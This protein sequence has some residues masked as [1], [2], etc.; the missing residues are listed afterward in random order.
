MIDADTNA[1]ETDENLIE[2]NKDP[3][4]DPLSISDHEERDSDTTL[5]KSKSKYSV[6]KRRSIR[7]SN[8]R[9]NSNTTNTN[10]NTNKSFKKY[11]GK[12]NTKE[13]HLLE[14]L[15]NIAEQEEFSLTV[16]KKLLVLHI[17]LIH[18]VPPQHKIELTGAHAPTKEEKR[19]FQKHGPLRRG[20]YSPAEDK[21]IRKN[22]NT[23]CDLHNWDPKMIQPFLYWRHNMKY[24]IDNVQERQR[25]VQFLANGL[26]WRTLFSVYSRFKTLYNNKITYTR[27][28]SE[29]DEK[30][31]MYIQNKHLNVRNTKYIELEKLLK[32]TRR[33]II[34]R[35]RFLKKTKNKSKNESSVNI[36]WTLPLIKE[37]IEN[38]LDVTL[39]EDIEELK[40][41][42]LPKSVWQKLEEKLNIHETVLKTFWQHQLHLQLFSTGPIYLND[43]KIKLIEYM[44]GKGISN[45][46]EIIW[47]NVARHFEGTTAAFLCKTFFYLVQDCNLNNVD[48]FADVIEYLYHTK[49]SEIQNA[50][51]DKFLPKIV[52]EQENIYI[53]NEKGD[54]VTTE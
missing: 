14:E 4:K 54:A 32:R 41:A 12:L 51:M 39:S 6:Q 7:L 13:K 17:K 48:N 53:L 35:Y 19:L 27:Y 23:F 34:K 47:P 49:I 20:P 38:L 28:T 24:Y 45:T 30:I 52:Y 36:N 40:Y 18:K 15:E 37:F 44:Y 25:F 11:K 43:I 46:R 21:I 1:Q 9:T 22:W 26:P 16:I 50:L 10:T 33:S 8:K 3:L 5:T 42:T 31:L 2:I 29:E